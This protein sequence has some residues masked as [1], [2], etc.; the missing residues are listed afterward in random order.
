MFVSVAAVAYVSTLD[1]LYACCARAV[2]VL[3]IVSF[4]RIAERMYVCVYIRTNH[5]YS[6]TPLQIMHR[7]I[8]RMLFRTVAHYCCM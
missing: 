3:S 4:I 6:N 5:T 1:V 8:V 2:H 7:I